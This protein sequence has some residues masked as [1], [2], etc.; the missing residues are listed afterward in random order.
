MK[1]YFSQRKTGKE[2]EEAPFA[3][4]LKVIS[5]ASQ[6][7]TSINALKNELR[8]SDVFVFI[9]VA[10]F[11]KR[12]KAAFSKIKTT[13]RVALFLSTFSQLAVAGSLE[14]LASI[15]GSVFCPEKNPSPDHG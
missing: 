10:L 3:Q 4:G 13:R 12:P 5:S 2:E 1:P 9:L 15:E 11:Q 7:N 8:Y 14:K 6:E